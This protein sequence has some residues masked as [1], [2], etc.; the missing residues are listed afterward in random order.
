LKQQVQK[1]RINKEMNLTC[2]FCKRKYISQNDLDSHTRTAKFCRDYRNIRF[3]CKKCN[4]ITDSIL[5][6]DKHTKT[7]TC[8]KQE[9]IIP[10]PIP[11]AIPPAI[12]P[13]D[14]YTRIRQLEIMIAIEKV[15]SD[16]WRSLLETN[17]SIKVPD[18][19]EIE[20]NTVIFLPIKGVDIQ[21]IVNNYIAIPTIVPTDD[22]NN[23]I[24]VDTIKKQNYKT[25]KGIIDLVP[26]R[27]PIIDICIEQENIQSN[28][29][30]FDDLFDKLSQT[31]FSTKILEDIKNK[32]LEMFKSMYLEDYIELINQHVKR[33]TDIFRAKKYIDKKINPIIC[34]GLSSLEARLITSNAHIENHIDIDELSTLL[35]VL[36]KKTDCNTY[37]IPYLE[38]TLCNKFYNY[39]IVVFPIGKLLDNF[40]FNKHDLHNIIYLPHA[41]SSEDD[42]Y[43]YYV[44]DNIKDN[45]RQ[46]RMDCRLEELVTS[47]TSNLLPYMI[48]MFR[49]LYKLVFNDNEF[50]SDYM[51][52]C[53]LTDGDCEQLLINIIIISKTHDFRK[54]I[55]YKIRQKS[56][57]QT[58]PNDKFNLY[59]DDPL[60]RKRLNDKECDAVDVIKQ[61]F[62]GI[63]TEDMVDFYRSRTISS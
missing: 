26:E 20:D 62:D 12:P 7:C 43:S 38:S 57:H 55:R 3:G 10:P 35:V 41:K 40:L 21:I 9:S 13:P 29:Q 31:R 33:I 25:A 5:N 23:H 49:I 34:K 28:T 52:K 32:R 54:L 59:C 46:W 2:E 63:S 30:Y 58:T 44:L 14:P 4:Y 37:Y 22:V 8:D 6:I 11:P 45:K 56:T 47:L 48:G 18:V 50:R 42:P 1:K 53:Q 24:Q 61:L 17:T 15:K 19:V 51:Y 39:G 27:V 16:I 60:Q 36:Q